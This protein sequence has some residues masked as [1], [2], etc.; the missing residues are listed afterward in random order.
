MSDLSDSMNKNCTVQT[1]M[2]DSFAWVNGCIILI[3]ASG[4]T[5]PCHTHFF[6]DFIS[7]TQSEFL[8]FLALPVVQYIVAW[9]L[10][11][12][13][14]KMSKYLNSLYLSFKGFEYFELEL[15]PL[16]ATSANAAHFGGYEVYGI[17][18]TIAP[19]R[20]FFI[21]IAKIT[22]RVIAEVCVFALWG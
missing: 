8:K 16:T 10:C 18:P 5:Q 6:R 13:L 20:I 7:V 9:S 2:T 4:C 3:L 19:M 22:F 21:F 17:V 1:S 11:S 12:Y 14:K 15:L